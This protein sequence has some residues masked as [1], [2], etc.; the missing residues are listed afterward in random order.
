MSH[1][2]SNSAEGREQTSGVEFN[3]LYHVR[4]LG[5]SIAQINLTNHLFF[6]VA[7]DGI[8]GGRGLDETSN[9]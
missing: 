1:D 4:L 5:F 8:S 9:G 6:T 7:R 3:L 2:G